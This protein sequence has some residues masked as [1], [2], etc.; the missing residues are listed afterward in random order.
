MGTPLTSN[1]RTH[2]TTG[3]E[4]LVL[5]YKL[6]EPLYAPL[7]RHVHPQIVA[8]TLLHNTPEKHVK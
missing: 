3:Q 2:H 7:C 5:A 6:Q 8:F 1:I 4:P